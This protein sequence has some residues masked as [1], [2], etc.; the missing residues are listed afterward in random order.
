MTISCS[1]FIQYSK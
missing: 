1:S